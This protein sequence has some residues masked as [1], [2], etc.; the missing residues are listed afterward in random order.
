MVSNIHA[1]TPAGKIKK[2]SYSMV[3]TWIKKSWDEVDISII[4]RSFKCCGVST[5][6]NGSE[7]NQLFQ[8][9]NLLNQVNN[10]NEELEEGS[11]PENPNPEEEYL[12]E[13]DYRNDWNIGDNRINNEISKKGETYNKG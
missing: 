12:E 13:I 10:T 11:S 1:F 9:E 2:P 3:A 4:K 8:Y 5:C 7:D 6:L